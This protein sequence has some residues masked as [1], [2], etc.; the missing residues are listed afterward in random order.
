MSNT[1][2]ERWTLEE[3]EEL[4]SI[5][6]ESKAND[7]LTIECFRSFYPNRSYAGVKRKLE[8]LKEENSAMFTDKEDPEHIYDMELAELYAWIH[9]NFVKK[10]GDKEDKIQLLQSDDLNALSQMHIDEIE[11]DAKTGELI[12][13]GCPVMHESFN[14]NMQDK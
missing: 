7:I 4:L 6:V 11:I 8:R 5:A 14:Y 12:V 1:T 10:F 2:K 3:I 9:D 13:T